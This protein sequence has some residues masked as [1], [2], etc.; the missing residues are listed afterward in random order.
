MSEAME[1]MMPIM[2]KSIDH[3]NHGLQDQVAK[4]R[5]DANAPASKN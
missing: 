4:M 5:T 1:T 2:R 3:M